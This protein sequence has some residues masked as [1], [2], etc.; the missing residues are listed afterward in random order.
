M[1]LDSVKKSERYWLNNY[2]KIRNHERER[3]LDKK[4]LAKLIKNIDNLQSVTEINN[5][6]YL[7]DTALSDI[8]QY[9]GSLDSRLKSFKKQRG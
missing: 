4:K 7:T 8:R 5:L 9:S 3:P 6:L 2:I 1:R